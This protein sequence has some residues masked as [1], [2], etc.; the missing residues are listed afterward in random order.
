[1]LII[2]FLRTGK[3]H[4]P[5]FKIVVVQ[6]EKS[7]KAGSFLEDLGFFNPLLDKVNLKK[8]R[9]LYWISK[10][11]SLSDTA[12]NLL[13][14][15]GII[16]G[17]KV[18]KDKLPKKKEEVAKAAPAPEVPKEEAKTEPETPVDTQNSAE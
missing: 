2:R 14:K 7:A 12:R 1:M 15:N 11:A 9:I 17:K 8:E 13:I 3:K 6:K 16:K 5:S 10:G 18:A 4:Q